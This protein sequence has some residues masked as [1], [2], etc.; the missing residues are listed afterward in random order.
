[1]CS[2]LN[3]VA[4][5]FLI[6][7]FL[8]RKYSKKTFVFYSYPKN[9]SRIKED[10]PPSSNTA[11]LHWWFAE[12]HPKKE[13]DFVKVPIHFWAVTSVLIHHHAESDLLTWNLIEKFWTTNIL[14]VI[15]ISLLLNLMLIFPQNLTSKGLKC[16]FRG[17]CFPKLG[18]GPHCRLSNTSWGVFKGFSETK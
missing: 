14:H 17:R 1:M 7:F 4:C 13:T 9:L 15:D 18:S 16:L 5:T 10:H 6:N 11:W 8:L 12:L 2:L 3:F